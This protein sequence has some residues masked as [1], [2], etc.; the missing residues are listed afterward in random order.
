MEDKGR[1]LFEITEV[2]SWLG[3]VA[4]AVAM[5]IV[6]TFT[7]FE[8]K[9]GV[10]DIR[11]DMTQRLDRIENKI[12]RLYDYRVQEQIQLK[13]KIVDRAIGGGK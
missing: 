5:G 8:T 6:F 1:V 4:T 13:D 2:I 10:S 7:T 9:A 12:D 11:L 3:A